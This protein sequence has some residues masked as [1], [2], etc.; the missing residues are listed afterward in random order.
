MIMMR[1][2]RSRGEM[3]V[4][5]K[6]EG[7]GGCSSILIIWKRSRCEP[8]LGMR[9]EKEHSDEITQ[10]MQHDLLPCSQSRRD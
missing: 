4:R 10:E 2:P 7:G 1:R 8:R 3:M 6:E 5:R 9:Q